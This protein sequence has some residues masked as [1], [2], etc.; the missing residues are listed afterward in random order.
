MAP[1]IQGIRTGLAADGDGRKVPAPS[2][3][4][5]IPWRADPIDGLRPTRAV[6]ATFAA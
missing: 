1:V 6:R 4:A 3:L 2:E 5:D